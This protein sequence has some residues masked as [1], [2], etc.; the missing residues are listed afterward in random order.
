MRRFALVSIM[1][2]VSAATFAADQLD[3]SVWRTIDDKTGK[4]RAMV[5]F[6]ET[7]GS[8]SGTV[9]SLLDKNATKVCE[10]CTGNLKNKPV[11]G[12]T[13][14]HGLRAVD[15]VKNSYDYGSILDPKSGKTYKL[16]GTLS[17][18][19]KT[20]NL[21]GYLGVSLLGRNQV[22]QRVQ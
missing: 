15:G 19:G 22:W 5:K 12:M 9:Q 11:V 18:D 4:P 1:M 10:K 8:L 2:A 7:N 20:F 3:G 14:V 21:R 17:D 6:T 13:L 16:K